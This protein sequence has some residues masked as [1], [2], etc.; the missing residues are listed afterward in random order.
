MPRALLGATS[1]FTLG[2]GL[3]WEARIYST[4]GRGARGAPDTAAL[5]A[6]ARTSEGPAFPGVASRSLP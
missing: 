5:S 2:Y 1:L 3:G 4:F 6:V